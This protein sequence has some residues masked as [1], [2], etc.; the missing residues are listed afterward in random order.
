MFKRISLFLLVN[1]LVVVTISLVVN[2][3][4]VKPYL[5]AYGIDY[6]SLFVLCFIWGMGGAV[7]SLLLS[8]RMATWMM[9]VQIVDSSHSLHQMV[10][11]LSRDA[12]LPKTPEVGIYNSPDLNAFATGPSARNSLVAVSS[13]LIA[14]M[15]TKQL[16]AIVGH[17]ITHIS[18]GDMVTLTL[19]QGVVNAFVM[20][21]A[22]ALALIA[23]GFGNSR[24]RNRGGSFMSYYMFTFLFEMVFML[25][26]S[27]VVAAFSR[28]REYRAD[29]GGAIL[30]GRDSM[31]SALQ[32][33][34]RQHTATRMNKAYS[35]LMISNPSPL[36][37]LFATH[38]PIASRIQRLRH[39]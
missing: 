27:T 25:L 10:E 16:E 11:R 20:F 31:I 19:L 39:G 8:K 24:D 28:W 4:G 17:E 1:L 34:D 30:A 37:R 9:G 38:P 15:D 13:G 32:A 12:G 5:T 36:M 33:L 3:L 23:S 6:E 21:L 22:R 29:A 7:I 2:L 26:G 14:H 35:A 18:N